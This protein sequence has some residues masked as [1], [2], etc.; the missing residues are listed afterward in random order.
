MSPGGTVGNNLLA[1]QG[2][3]VRAPG[4]EDP[5]E[6]EMATHSSILPWEIPWREEP[7][8]LQSTESK[9][10]RARLTT[11][12]QIEPI[13]TTPPPTKLKKTL[14]LSPNVCIYGLLGQIHP[15]DI[16]YLACSMF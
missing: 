14:L 9:K 13:N 11:K 12:R 16:L 15:R 1:K 6:Q 7:V 2:T 4:W 3:Q 8:G 5:L 10:S